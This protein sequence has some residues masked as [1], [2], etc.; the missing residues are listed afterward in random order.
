MGSLDFPSFMTILI[1]G[2]CTGGVYGLFSSSFSFQLGALNVADFSFGSWLMLSMYL[3]FFMYKEW[4]IGII[5]FG[6]I[7]FGSYFIISFLMSKFIYI[8]RKTD[9]NMI[10]TMGISLIIQNAATL[11]FS[12]YPRSLGI[13]EKTIVVGGVQITITK[14]IMLFLSAILLLGFQLFLNKTWTGKTIRAVVQNKE[15]ASLMGINS[16]RV[17][18]L[19]FSLSYVMLAA[20]GIM[21]VTLFSV[22]PTAGGFYQMMSFFICI[23]AGLGNIRGAFFSGLLIGFLKAILNIISSQFAMVMMFLIFVIFLVV[24]PTGL[25]TAKSRG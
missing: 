4:N 14:L 15:V 20:S 3:T 8:K 18:N 23:I 12:S 13:I 2:L 9:D 25:F 1:S 16:N 11:L 6:V 22:E 10:I 5:P 24:K 21:L 7:L 19:A 17:I